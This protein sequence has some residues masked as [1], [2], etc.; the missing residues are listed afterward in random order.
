MKFKTNQRSTEYLQHL[1]FAYDIAVFAK[2]NE[3]VTSFI[4]DKNKIP[5]I[6]VNELLKR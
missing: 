4:Y 5:K 3:E 2:S 6:L 1:R